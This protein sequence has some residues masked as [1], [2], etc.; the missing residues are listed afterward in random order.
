MRAN[1][2]FLVGITVYVSHGLTPIKV[3]QFQTP[4]K[5]NTF[6]QELSNLPW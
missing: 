4:K 6:T 2:G 5:E 3:F 1:L